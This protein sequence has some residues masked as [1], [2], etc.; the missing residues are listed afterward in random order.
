MMYTTVS[1]QQVEFSAKHGYYPEEQ[2]IGNRFEVTVHCKF[3]QIQERFV[4]YERLYE[5]VEEVMKKEQPEK[6]LE[7]LCQLIMD[8]IQESFDFLE[9]VNLEIVKL[10]PPIAR[11][12]GKGTG[13]Q[14]NW[15]R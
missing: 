15:K 10:S 12:D 11:F 1:L 2:L 13:V 9:E 6:F 7:G 4:N 8:E 5:I 14:L 3:E